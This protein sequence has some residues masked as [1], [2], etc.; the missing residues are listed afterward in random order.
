LI[1]C[2]GLNMRSPSLHDTGRSKVCD[3]NLNHH[4]NR[5]WRAGK[6]DEHLIDSALQVRIVLSFLMI[7]ELL[8]L[9]DLVLRLNL[10]YSLIAPSQ[11]ERN[12]QERHDEQADIGPFRKA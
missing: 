4:L 8:Y 3:S 5:F 11:K 1:Y 6:H 9:R 12:K 10:S 7:Q 2:S